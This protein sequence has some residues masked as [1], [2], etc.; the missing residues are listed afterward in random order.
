MATKGRPTIRLKAQ[1]TVLPMITEKRR[2][3]SQKPEELYAFIESLCPGNKVELFSRTDRKNWTSWGAEAGSLE[4]E[5][6]L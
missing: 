5:L 6:G 3:H 4:S 1:T 2:E